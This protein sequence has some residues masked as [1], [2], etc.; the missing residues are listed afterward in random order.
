MEESFIILKTNI[1]SET[2][3]QE[4]IPI[5]DNHKGINSW[6]IDL[7]DVDKV[8]RIEAN[9]ELKQNDVL[10]II[11]RHGYIGEELND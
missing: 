3:I 9:K 8:L 10:R 4:L 6:S 2:M 7:E 11:S 1:K 5:F